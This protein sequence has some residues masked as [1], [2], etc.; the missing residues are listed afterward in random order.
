MVISLVDYVFPLI[1]PLLFFIGVFP[2][3]F[4][5]TERNELL[6]PSGVPFFINLYRNTNEK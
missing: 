6:P 2:S 1:F 4:V 5:I 3:I